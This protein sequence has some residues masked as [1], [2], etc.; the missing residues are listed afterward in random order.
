VRT[1]ELGVDA[2]GQRDD[3]RAVGDVDLAAA[4]HRRPT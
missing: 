2:V 1:T 3:G 4:R